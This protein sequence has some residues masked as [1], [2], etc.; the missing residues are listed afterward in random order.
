MVKEI[1]EA[2]KWERPVYFAVTC[3]EDSKIGLS[4]YLKMEGMA[5]KLVPEKEQ[6]VNLSTSLFC[7][8]SFLMNLMIFQW[9]IDRFKFRALMINQSSLMK[10]M[11]DLLKTIA[12]PLSASHSTISAMEIK[13]IRQL[14]Y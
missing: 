10:I 8:N 13:R 6:V 11:K 9:I 14:K 2:N 1:I 5:L 3:S 7:V 12:T 4:D